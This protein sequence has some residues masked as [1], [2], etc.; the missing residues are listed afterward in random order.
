MMQ[1]MEREPFGAG[2]IIRD[3]L[4]MD[5]VINGCQRGRCNSRSSGSRSEARAR[6]TLHPRCSPDGSPGPTS[7][8]A[9]A[10]GPPAM[11]PKWP[12]LPHC[13]LGNG[14]QHSVTKGGGW[15]PSSP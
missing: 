10:A 14:V 9:R 7:W 4:H 5:Q 11:G 8:G 6:T 15:L 3:T 12:H 2:K 1:V 13:S